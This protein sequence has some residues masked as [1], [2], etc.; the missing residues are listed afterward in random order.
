[1]VDPQFMAIFEREH[2]DEALE[3]GIPYFHTNPLTFKNKV[4]IQKILSVDFG[5]G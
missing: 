4:V 3:F 5:D 2:G 1:M